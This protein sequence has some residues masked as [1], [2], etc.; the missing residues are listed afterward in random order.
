MTM[1]ANQ[2][3]KMNGLQRLKQN[4]KAVFAAALITVMVVLWAKAL[5]GN[6][7]QKAKAASAQIEAPAKD[8][9]LEITYMELPQQA[10]RN[11]LLTK[12][13]FEPCWTGFVKEGQDSESSDM[14]VLSGDDK[15]A[16]RISGLMKL[17]AI[18]RNNNNQPEAFI[19]ESLLK[20][21][22]KLTVNDNGEK[23]ECDVVS[24]EEKQVEI[25]FEG[26]KISLKM[27]VDESEK[28]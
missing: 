28:D 21:G 12:D 18:S 17:Q 9:I 23:Y 24:I 20:V 8:K 13:F 5:T 4:K 11:D 1:S 3:I 25:N 2:Q 6:G 14:S 22:D 16:L 26:T 15:T 27:I 10:G 19:N 7:P